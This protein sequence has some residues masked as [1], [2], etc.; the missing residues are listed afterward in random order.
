MLRRSRPFVVF[1]HGRGAAEYYDTRP[2]QVFDLF[3]DYGLRVSLMK[4]WLA[5]GSAKAFTRAGFIDEFD[6]GRNFY[7]LAHPG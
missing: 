5:H 6:T 4:D 7:Y 2:E 1:E 3:G